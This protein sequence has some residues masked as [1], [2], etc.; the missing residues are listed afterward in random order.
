MNAA[1][2]TREILWNISYSWLMYALLVPTALVAG[3]GI[4]RKY[5]IWKLGKP[6][7]RFDR[8]GER[9]KLVLQHGL[10]QQRT[11]RQS[12]AGTF[13][14]M[15]FTGFIVLTIATTVVAI[16]HDFGLQIMKGS[17]YLYFQSFIVD[18]FGALVM[19][20]VGLAAWRRWK[21]RPK[22][23]VYTDEATWILV[24]IFIIS[25]T[26]F[27][28]EAW[29]IAATDDPWGHW[30]PVG[31]LMSGGF[32]AL[33]SDSEMQALHLYGW[34]FHLTLVF[35][36]IAW[37]PYTKMAHV[38][39]APLNIFTANLDG[40]GGSL[41]RIDFETAESF[42]V[43]ALAD[44]TWKD[45]LD[46]DACTECGRCTA[47]CPANTVG[48]ALSPR[49]II[50]DLR[51]LMHASEAALR[52]VAA[53]EP[54]EKSPIIDD[55]SAVRAE[56]LWQCT[57]CAAC[58]EACPVFIEQMPK[59][60]DARRYLVMEEADF[61]EELMATVTSLEQRGHPFP[62]TSFSRI[63]WAEGLDV[64]ILGEMEDPAEA[65][66][67]LWVGCGGALVERNQST[68]RA[69]AQLLNEA[70]I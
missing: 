6:I 28:L 4:F 49:D 33:L 64:E 19:I 11:A 10:G 36:F 51:N 12:Y 16:Q 27:F 40:Y 35:G 46:L 25:L 21:S 54:G 47:V 60:V 26:G 61:P 67:V 17:F 37:A 14:L 30:S 68:V 29:R 9:T 58:M 38:V 7:L 24:I 18:V 15:I 39:T 32:D 22:Q 5:R 1:E 34:W 65:E 3:F 48:K 41:K 50:L 53:A 57:T 52:S 23:L 66:I 20:G 63:D 44:F 31:F 59:I 13:H 8:V 45:L 42:G 2:A 62:G 43:N 56:A 69:L 55:D 70:G